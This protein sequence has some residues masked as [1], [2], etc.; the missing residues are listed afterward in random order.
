MSRSVLVAKKY[1]VNFEYI[2]MSAA[3]VDECL[4]AL[5]YYDEDVINHTNAWDFDLFTL[6]GTDF[7]LNKKVVKRFI[8]ENADTA[9]AVTAQKLLDAS[10]PDNSYIV[11]YIG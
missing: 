8:Q 1:D 2:N 7:E 4:K 11:V 3:D 9:V 5:Y 6:D 10:D